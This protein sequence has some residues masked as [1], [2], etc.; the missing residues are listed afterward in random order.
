M[1][2]AENQA[3]ELA[4]ECAKLLED[5]NQEFGG[6][7]SIDEVE[8]AILKSIPLVQLL[9][10]NAELNKIA[11]SYR[12]A[13]DDMVLSLRDAFKERDSLREENKG[14]KRVLRLVLPM[15]KGYAI[16]NQVGNNLEFV[17]QT[18]ELLST[19]TRKEPTQ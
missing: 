3:E 6:F 18:E 19:L 13:H 17:R 9:S 11:D 1:T 8:K 2:P 4:R 12:A 10:E 7:D 14:L 15:A 5:L 16:K